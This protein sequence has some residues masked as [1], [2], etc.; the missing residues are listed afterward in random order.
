MSKVDYASLF[1]HLP[2]KKSA[3]AI[4]DNK[5][6]TKEKLPSTIGLN[7]SERIDRNI[8]ASSY[9]IKRCD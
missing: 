9:M 4:C 7:I 8:K 1:N 2:V 3:A 6:V 5:F